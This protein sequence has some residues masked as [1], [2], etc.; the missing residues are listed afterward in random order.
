VTEDRVR[1]LAGQL[2]AGHVDSLAHLS[3]ELAASSMTDLFLRTG[4]AQARVI[5]SAEVRR[6]IRLDC[7]RRGCRVRTFSAHD[8][9]VVYDEQRHEAFLGTE[10]GA[11]YLDEM[12]RRMRSAFDYPAPLQ[13]P[14]RLLTTEE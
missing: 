13:P 5:D 11:A 14:L 3:S 9:V 4:Y 6:L 12:D 10:A 1:P 8:V 2:P 7:R